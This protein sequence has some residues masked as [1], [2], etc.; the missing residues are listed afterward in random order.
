MRLRAR[1]SAVTRA[2]QFRGAVFQERL[3]PVFNE[4]VNNRTNSLVKL[5]YVGLLNT[6]G[7]PVVAVGN[8][9]LLTHEV[10]AES[11]LWTS[12]YVALV[13]PLEGASVNPRGATNN[14][15]TVVLPSFRNFTNARAAGRRFYGGDRCPAGA[16]RHQ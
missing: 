2:L 16:S 10:L 6:N 5:V 13:L 4:L 8:T 14:N 12:N 11:E 15:A 9:N 1:L 7:E 3:E